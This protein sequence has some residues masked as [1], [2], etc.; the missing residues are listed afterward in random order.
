MQL[1]WSIAGITFL[2]IVAAFC[3]A[4]LVASFRAKPQP[5]V[6]APPPAKVNVVVAAKPL[7]AMTV[8][9]KDDVALIT[10]DRDD[11]PNEAFSNTVQVIGKVL[12]APLVAG[13]PLT[14]SS[15]VDQDPGVQMAANLPPGMRAVSV[16]VDEHSGVRG[17][18]YPG[19]VVDVL[20][21]FRLPSNASGSKSGQAVAK[22][23]LQKIRVLAVGDKTLYSK[24]DPQEITDIVQR[25]VRS[26]RRPVVTLMVDAK[27]TKALQLAAAHGKISLAIRNPEDQIHTEDQ[28]TVLRDGQIKALDELEDELRLAGDIPTPQPQPEPIIPVP[29]LFELSED[30]DPP[31]PPPMWEMRI[32]RGAS[33]EEIKSFP[34]PEEGQTP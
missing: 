12:S 22:I 8:V 18:L 16:E 26:S 25:R 24:H 4:A 34:V 17:H 6:Q 20:A 27:Q 14:Q 3:A 21:A 33:S 13:Q 30:L 11:A 23:F 31:P 28:A 15:I 19:C 1:R 7:S 29:S 2:G 32:I 9:S 10:A 5:V